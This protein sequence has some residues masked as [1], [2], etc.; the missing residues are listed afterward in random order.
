MEGENTA[1][2]D[3][4]PSPQATERERQRSTIGFPYDDL[5]ASIELADAIHGNVGH[6]DCDDSQLAAWTNQSP[7]SSG[8]RTAIY[9]ARMFGVID[10]DAGRHRLTELGRSIVDP[11]QTREARAR[12]FLNVPL[13]SA[14]FE[15]HNGGTLPPAA[16]L[17]R[18]MIGL[19]VAEKQKGR[20]RQVFERAAEQAGFFEHGRNRLVMP[21][22]VQ[23]GEKVSEP[24]KKDG[25]GGGNGGNGGDIDPVIAALIDKLPKKGPWPLDD[26][27][28]WLQML[29]M[30]IQLA[31]GQEGMIEIKKA[32]G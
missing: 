19:G 1:N 5:N 17:E 15:S 20:A 3:A 16:A 29:S 28:M 24:E 14:I 21:G 23:R 2:V 9:A 25:G 27:I 12:A 13:Y 32:A 6:G 18:E 11:Q 10:G 31:Y 30:A 22:F 7:K 26:R 8:F 4:P